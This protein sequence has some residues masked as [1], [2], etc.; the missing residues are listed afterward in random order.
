MAQK[1]WPGED[2]LGKKISFEGGKAKPKW[3]EIVGI[4]N[5]IKHKGLEGESRVQ[6]Y[7]PYRQRPT[8]DMYLVIRTSVE[9][10]SVS[11]A[12]RST[13]ASID[14]DLPVFRVT[15]MDQLVAD[16]MVQRR[17][18][19]FL[20]GTFALLALVLAVVG[21]YGVM[22]YM[23]SQRTREIGIRMAL[24]ARLV[25]I[26]RLVVSQGM[27]M[28]VV[29]VLIGLAGAFALTRLMAS[30]LFGITATDPVTFT[31]VSLLL[32]GVALAACLI[33]ARRAARVNPTV[34]LRYE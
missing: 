10:S 24:G 26:I 9:A 14:K 31:A 19:L 6:Y 25:D 16:S 5:H 30:L 8:P 18:S 29:G 3:R 21:I 33:P 15:T 17:F 23:V 28:V 13:I 32:A 12:V 34:A 4:V 27:L 20:F 1:Y 7:Y 22:S 2:P 11:A